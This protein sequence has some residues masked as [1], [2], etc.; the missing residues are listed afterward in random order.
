MIG[1]DVMARG[2]ARHLV[3]ALVLLA[4]GCSQ[5]TPQETVTGATTANGETS[6]ADNTQ[7]DETSTTEAVAGTTEADGQ[8]STTASSTSPSTSSSSTSTTVTTTTE[9]QPAVLSGADVLALSD[10]ESLTGLRVGLIGNQ[11]SLAG[12]DHLIDLLTEATDVELVAAF[13][14]EHGIR[15]I[16][17]AGEVLDDDVDPVTGIPIVSLY[18]SNRAPP[19]DSLEGIDILLFDL[20]SVGTRYYTYIS[21]MGLSMQAAAAAGIPFVVLDRP[22]P[23]GG[24]MLEGLMRAPAQESFIGQYPIPSVYALTPGELALA[25]KGERW[26]DGL[27]SLDLRVVELVGWDRSQ[28]WVDTE[29]PWIGPSPG[30]PTI[31][32]ATVYPGT[33]LFEATTL[34][35]GTGTRH[36]FSSIGAPWIDSERLAADVIASTEASGLEGFEIEAVSYTPQV[37]PNVSVRPRFEGEKVFGIRITVTDAAAYQPTVVGVHMLI[38]AQTQATEQGLGSIIDRPRVFDLLAGSP[39]LQQQL[40]AGI[41]ADDIVAGWQP[42]LE[43]FRAT[44]SPYLLYD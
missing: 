23:H 33:V 15:G 20:Q 1:R 30:L 31:E 2:A 44:T 32:A 42:A 4:G 13:A 10:F 34:S 8:T 5:V 17:D 26:L 38:A 18:G 11:T 16:A 28:T 9:P 19:Q 27:D 40:Q 39:A 37:I 35:Y 21:T 3:V 14:P 25:I 41:S 22:N 24:V 43:E 6:V 7:V 12:D 29:R 36:P